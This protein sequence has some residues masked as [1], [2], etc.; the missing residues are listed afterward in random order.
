M[1]VRMNDHVFEVPIKCGK[2]GEEWLGR[3]EAVGLKYG[4]VHFDLRS[5]GQHVDTATHKASFGERL[6][7][8]L[9]EPPA[10]PLPP[11]P[12]AEVVMKKRVVKLTDE[13]I[14]TFGF[15]CPTCRN[16]KILLCPECKKY[17]CQGGQRDTAGRFQC[18]W[19]GTTLMFRP[20]TD[21]ETARATPTEI[22]SSE[23]R[24]SLR[25]RELPPGK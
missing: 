10:L 12:N 8:L 3:L 23:K 15:E 19:C 24:L 9:S 14:I 22:V 16:D 7:A 4:F 17:S 6:R 11:S 2:T 5:T 21:D 1:G 18:Q 13:D 25:F 20:L